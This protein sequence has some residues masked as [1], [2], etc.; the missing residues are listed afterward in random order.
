[1]GYGPR[2]TKSKYIRAR[3]PHSILSPSPSSADFVSDLEHDFSDLSEDLDD[4]TESS[5]TLSPTSMPGPKLAIS[6]FNLSCPSLSGEPFPHASRP[7]S[8]VSTSSSGSSA[9]GISTHQP[10]TPTSPPGACHTTLSSS[11]ESEG[12]TLSSPQMI[13]SFF[14][15]I[16]IDWSW[17]GEP[18]LSA[19]VISMIPFKV[20]GCQI[21]I[22]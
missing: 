15:Q 5:P 1:M 8:A 3:I 9:I 22:Y 19:A 7:V 10:H 18:N 21:H 13:L 16:I 6:S 17:T 2:F 4:Y 12:D 20:H 14:Q 11:A